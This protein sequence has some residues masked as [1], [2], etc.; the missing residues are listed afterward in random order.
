MAGVSTVIVKMRQGIRDAVLYAG[1]V[2]D[3]KL[4]IK[5][6]LEVNIGQEDGV[7]EGGSMEC[8]EHV[9]AVFVVCK[10]NYSANINTS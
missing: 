4:D 1:K 6:Y 7:K 10:D 3:T 2:E 8:I 5:L 9:D